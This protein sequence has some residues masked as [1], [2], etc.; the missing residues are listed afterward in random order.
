MNRGLISG[1][2]KRFLAFPKGPHRLWFSTH[3]SVK[4]VQRWNL[5]QGIK[6]EDLHSVPMLGMRG[7][8]PPPP[9]VHGMVIKNG[10]DFT[11]ASF[12]SDLVYIYYGCESNVSTS[13]VQ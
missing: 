6:D 5:S 9:S 4:W 1:R 3:T 12:T 2:A 8:T 7:V 10:Q 11:C 13:A